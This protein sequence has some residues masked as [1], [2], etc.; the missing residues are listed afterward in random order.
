VA[1][2]VGTWLR[3]GSKASFRIYYPKE[4]FEATWV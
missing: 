4:A 1:A 3:G 2:I